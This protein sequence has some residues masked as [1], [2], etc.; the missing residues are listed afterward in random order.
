MKNICALITLFMIL[1]LF[2][3]CGVL[4]K[5]KAIYI[6]G[7]EFCVKFSD[8]TVKADQINSPPEDDN[9]V[10]YTKAY[11]V[12]D[13]YTLTVSEDNENRVAFSIRY[14]NANGKVEFD[15]VERFDVVESVKIPINGFV[16]TMLSALI[17][18]VRAHQ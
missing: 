15:I 17:E 14:L 16:L 1:P 18:G 2:V 11:K 5:V 9:V 6:D 12:K 3:S 4:T 10:V 8:T 13:E 7:F